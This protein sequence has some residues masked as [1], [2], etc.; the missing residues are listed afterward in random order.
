MLKGGIIA[1]LGL[2]HV[3]TGDGKGKT[4]A[5]MGL[6]LR[7]IGQ[8]CRVSIIQFMK[9]GAYTGELIAAANF[10]PNVKVAQYG[11]PCTKEKRELGA[12]GITQKF[13]FSDHLRGSIECG[14]CRWCFLNDEQQAAFVMEAFEHACRDVTSGEFN[15]VVLDEINVAEHLKFLSIESILD[16]IERKAKHTELILTGR[17]AHEKIIKRVDYANEVRSIKHPFER[18]TPA[19]RVYSTEIT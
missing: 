7:A 2:V 13:H 14:T 10:L 11:R 1:D 3:Y 5:S 4:S 8:G 15:I 6:A 18:G 17:N 12:K 9:G 19:R 16:L